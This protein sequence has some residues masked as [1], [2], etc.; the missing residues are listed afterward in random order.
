MP[1]PIL[2]E[3]NVT[4][5]KEIWPRVIFDQFFKATPFAAYLRNKCLAPFGG[6]AFMQNSHIV[7]PM[8]GG[9]YAPGGTWNITKRQTLTATVFDP[10]YYEVAVPEYLEVIL[11]ENVGELAAFSLVNT[12]LTNA[13]NT[14]TAIVAIDLAR[15]GQVAG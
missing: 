7:R 4:T 15:H 14:I 13:M 12:D 10:K 6:G 3:L 2:D 8:I 11:V 1:D 5:I 9:A